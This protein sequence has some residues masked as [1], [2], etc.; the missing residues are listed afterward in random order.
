MKAFLR[1]CTP[2]L[3]LLS[4]GLSTEVNATTYLY[5]GTPLSFTYDCTHG[6]LPPLPLDTTVAGEVVFN[7]DTTSSSGT[8]TMFSSAIA[9]RTLVF[10][11]NSGSFVPTAFGTV[12]LTSGIITAWSLSNG[13]PGPAGTSVSSTTTGDTVGFLPSLAS[14][15][16]GPGT[17]SGPIADNFS[18]P[19]PGTL[20]LFATGLGALGL[21]GSRKKRKPVRSV[22]LWRLT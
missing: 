21:L 16:A 20:P 11:F 3:T 19:L 15:S 5:Q 18:V 2:L 1:F 14:G 9:F 8:F 12:T 6:C 22:F 17:W 13:I 4:I 10:S 7:F